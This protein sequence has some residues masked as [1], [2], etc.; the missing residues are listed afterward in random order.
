MVGRFFGTYLMN[1]IEPRAFLAR[2]ALICVTL[3]AVALFTSSYVAVFALI[4]VNFF[5]SIMFP[6]IYALGLEKLGD[7]AEVGSSLIIMTIISGAMIPPLMGFWAD[8]VNVQSAY[9]IPFVC[10][11]VVWVSLKFG[12]E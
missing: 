9:F 10:F 8:A 12:K 4:A 1:K 6:T 5:M 11:A 3:V 2:Y 7:K